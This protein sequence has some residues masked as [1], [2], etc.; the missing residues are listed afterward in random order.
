V[1]ST[2]GR[3]RDECYGGPAQQIGK[4]EQCHAFGDPR[5]V[6]IPGLR[7]SDGTIHF[8]IASHEYEKCYTVYEH[9]ENYVNQAP[10]ASS[11]LKGQASGVLAI[12][13]HAKQG[14][15]GHPTGKNPT[16]EHYVRCVFK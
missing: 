15:C 7:A 8:Q 6:R 5:V 11:G 4:H 3:Q 16:T 9:Q 14:Q 12:I 2:D 1:K 10:R 13:G